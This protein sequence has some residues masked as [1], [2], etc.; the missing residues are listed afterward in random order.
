MRRQFAQVDDL[1][2]IDPLF[3]IRDNLRCN[4]RLAELAVSFLKRYRGK[5]KPSFHYVEE[6][7]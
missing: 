1:G 5:P 4:R 6:E 7:Y 3:L 2:I